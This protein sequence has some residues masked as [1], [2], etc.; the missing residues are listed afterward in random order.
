MALHAYQINKL[1][2]HYVFVEG[3][4]KQIV[5]NSLFSSGVPSCKTQCDNKKMQISS[6]L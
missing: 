5:S 2:F 3:L 1:H 4:K 6:V